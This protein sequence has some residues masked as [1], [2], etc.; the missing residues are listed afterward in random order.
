MQHICCKPGVQTGT[1]KTEINLELSGVE[2]SIPVVASYSLTPPD[3]AHGIMDWDID[4][5]GL[6]AVDPALQAVADSIPLHKGLSAALENEICDVGEKRRR[7]RR[8]QNAEINRL[9]K[10]MT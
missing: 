2:W 7:L 6:K 4:V 3:A 1:Y 8:I 9:I 10:V 5:D